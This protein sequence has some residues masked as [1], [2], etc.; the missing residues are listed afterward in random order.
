VWSN[1]TLLRCFTVSICGGVGRFFPMVIVVG[2]GDTTGALGLFQKK[3]LTVN[4][5]TFYFASVR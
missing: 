1:N 4:S 2:R 3:C 5:I